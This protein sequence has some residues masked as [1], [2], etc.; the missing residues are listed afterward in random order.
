LVVAERKQVFFFFLFLTTV[1]LCV[2]VRR[3]LWSLMLA[4]CKQLA[5]S[6]LAADWPLAYSTITR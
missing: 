4:A 2:R 5:S 6:L 1:T 3:F